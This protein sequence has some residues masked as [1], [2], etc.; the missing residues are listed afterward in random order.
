MEQPKLENS[1]NEKRPTIVL[2]LKEVMTAQEVIEVQDFVKNKK[3]EFSVDDI[4][5]ANFSKTQRNLLKQYLDAKE[6]PHGVDP[7]YV[8]PEEESGIIGSGRDQMSE[9]NFVDFMSG[10]K[11]KDEGDVGKFVYF[12][13]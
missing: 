4:E 2:K 11:S 7:D 5:E 12:S 8:R 10:G 6:D 13:F 1:G 9:E 3:G